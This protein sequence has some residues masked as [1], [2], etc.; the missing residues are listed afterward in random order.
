MSVG[1]VI[2]E[3]LISIEEGSQVL[4]KCSSSRKLLVL[5]PVCGC[6]YFGNKDIV[7]IT[8]IFVCH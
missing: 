1:L 5:L 8:Q 6:Y 3:V 7:S 2:T 4:H